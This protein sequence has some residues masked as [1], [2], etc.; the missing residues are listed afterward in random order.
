MKPKMYKGLRP[1]TFKFMGRTYQ[2]SYP[3]ELQENFLGLTNHE[4]HTIEVKGTQP[5]LEEADTLI[6]EIFHVLWHH[7][8]MTGD[9]DDNLEERIVR[10]MATA[11]TVA[12]QE[13]PM[14]LEYLK[15][16]LKKEA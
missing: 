4:Q 8:G 10:A 5:P 13:N 14:L 15:A 12:A 16:A 6:H 11:F 9:L 1:F 7:M 3:D 2:V